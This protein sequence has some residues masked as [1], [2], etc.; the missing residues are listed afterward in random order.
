MH[1]A[2]AFLMVL[3]DQ[4]LNGYDLSLSCI[5]SMLSTKA[6]LR[7]YI[8]M[9]AHYARS[10]KNYSAKIRSFIANTKLSSYSGILKLPLFRYPRSNSS[11]QFAFKILQNDLAN[12]CL[13]SIDDTELE[14]DATN[15]AKGAILN[16][17][18]F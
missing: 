5:C 11:G 6:E 17:N 10:I 8:G 3:L 13:N 12:A 18:G 4:T 7:L 2:I 15:Y 16:Q 1:L 14:C 9:F